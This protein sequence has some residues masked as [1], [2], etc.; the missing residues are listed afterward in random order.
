M[1]RNFRLAAALV[2]GVLAAAVPSVTSAVVIINI[3]NQTPTA[4]SSDSVL[5]LTVYATD[6][7]NSNERLNAYIIAIDGPNFTPDG[8]RFVVPGSDFGRAGIPAAPHPYVFKDFATVP[9]IE[10]YN[11]TY[12]RLQFGAFAVGDEDEVDVGS[13][14]DGLLRI[15]VFFPANWYPLHGLPI[16]TLVVDPRATSLAGL[17]SPIVAVPGQAGVIAVVPE[18]SAAALLLL[19]SLALLRRRRGQMWGRAA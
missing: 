12:N 19:S 16:F 17:G 6:V 2:T 13:G 7:D 1:R 10:N 14:H 3:E 9:P 11:S 4:T 8:V 5:Y 18:P 15:G